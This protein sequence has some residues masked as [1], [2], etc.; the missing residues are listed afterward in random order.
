MICITALDDG[1]WS[2]SVVPGQSVCCAG[3]ES[4]SGTGGR[5]R[6]IY[7]KDKRTQVELEEKGGWIKCMG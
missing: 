3:E 2:P 1:R 4:T 6:T 7:R 5:P